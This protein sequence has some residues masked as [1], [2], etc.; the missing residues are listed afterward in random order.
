MREPAAGGAPLPL[1]EPGGPMQVTDLWGTDVQISNGTPGSLSMRG[2]ATGTDAAGV[3]YAAGIH[4]GAGTD[5]VRI[6]RST[7][8]GTSWTGVG[9][10]Q[11]PGKKIQSFALHV[12]DTVNATIVGTVAS[13]VDPASRQ[14]GALWW[15]SFRGNGT[16]FRSHLMLNPSAGRGLNHPTLVSDGFEF[17]PGI[18]WWFAAAAIVDSNGAAEGVL[19]LRS[20][21]FGRTWPY[22][23]TVRTGFIDGFP[24][25]EYENVLTGASGT[26][27]PNLPVP[28]NGVLT[29]T[30]T[31]NANIR[32]GALHVRIDSIL[33]PS[34]QDLDV[35]LFSPWGDSIELFTDIG[36]TGDNIV[37]ALL[38]DSA[39][40]R[41]TTGSAP[42]TGVWKPE[43]SN[44]PSGSFSEWEGF[45]GAGEW[46]L[47][48]R[49]DAPQ[50]SGRLVSWSLWIDPFSS[51]EVYVSTITDFGTD[52]DVRV[53]KSDAAYGG[54]N[55][56]DFNALTVDLDSDFDADLASRRGDGTLVLLHTHVTGSDAD[57]WSHASTDA[58]LTWE[59][60]VPLASGP[61]NQRY[62]TLAVADSFGPVPYVAAYLGTGDSVVLL[63]ADDPADFGS[64]P[65]RAVNDA[66]PAAGVRP[67]AGARMVGADPRA[68]VVY[69]R[70]SGG[71][72]YDGE[73]LV[74][75]AGGERGIPAAVTLAHNYPNP[76]NP[77]TLIGFTI[78]ARTEVRLAVY[79]VLGREVAVLVDGPMHAGTHEVRFSA[80][81]LASGVYLAMLRADGAVRTRP[82][83][84]LR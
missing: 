46:V 38:S 4:A 3:I 44:V 34:V 32:V 16:G 78:S 21:D 64:A 41:I 80:T 50:D 68:H 37:R 69:Y 2:L 1:A 43:A 62:P 42:F 7:T 11:F 75:S 28:D 82:M 76:F 35:F 55:G 71:I 57:I 24:S 31:I 47:Q 30:I 22:I 52:T 66:P 10:Y 70:S 61:G 25:I 56:W 40:S 13:V 18:T 59:G 58:G 45:F 83:L 67:E 65:R 14:D 73:E 27:R 15:A 12:T 17:A 6:Y 8:G 19:A 26:S 84:L 49:D 36:G 77:A 23:D 48:V 39:L 63:E 9:G 74:T 60:P 5:T 72:F 53:F 54:L 51:E 33:H 79:D 81:G 29:D 20:T